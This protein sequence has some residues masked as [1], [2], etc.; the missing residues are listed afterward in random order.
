MRGLADERQ[1]D[2]FGIGLILI[3]D[4]F[5]KDKMRSGIGESPSLSSP[6]A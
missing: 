1:F 3:R 6:V 5:G 2:E 4:V